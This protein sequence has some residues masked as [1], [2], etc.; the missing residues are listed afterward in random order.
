LMPQRY[1][2]GLKV[3]HDKRVV[4]NACHIMSN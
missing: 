4:P 2:D 3:L 1:C